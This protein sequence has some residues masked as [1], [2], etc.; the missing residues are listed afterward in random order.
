MICV[1]AVMLFSCTKISVKDIREIDFKTASLFYILRF[2]LFP[3]AA[4]FIALYTVEEYATGVLIMALMPAGISS[5]P[6]ANIF[7]GNPSLA[8]IA[9]MVSHALIPFTLPLITSFALGKGIEVN[10]AH[11]M[12][13]LSLTIFAPAALYFC[14]AKRIP[15]VKNWMTI[16]AQSFSIALIATM[17]AFVTAPQ[18][19]SI[20]ND[21]TLTLW[22][23][24]ITAI[25]FLCFYL[26]AWV[27]A[28]K[29]KP[30]ERRT[31]GI[32]SGAN[33]NA[34]AAG[35][36]AMYFGPSTILFC[37]LSEITWIAALPIYK[38]V[39]KKMAE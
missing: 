15:N 38:Y 17:V 22:P 27:F 2:L 26:F 6:L 4:Y 3:I 30:A 9:M 28:Y 23:L 7:K 10:S 21:F 36:A 18:K 16:N 34:L 13:T 12:L 29:Q 11:M 19:L 35:L 25:L 24:F 5:I 14:A 31:Y 37:V 8:L 1:A 32:I 20:L 33:N 39:C